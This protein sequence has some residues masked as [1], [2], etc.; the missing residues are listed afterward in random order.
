MKK[1][2]TA[3]FILFAA[4]SA[5][6]ESL[7]ITGTR[8][9]SEEHLIKTLNLNRYIHGHIDINQVNSL[10][11]DY[12]HREGYNLAVVYL[13]DDEKES[14]RLHVDEGRLGKIV[15]YNLSSLDTLRVKTVFRLKHRIFNIYEVR[16]NINTLAEKF[17]FYKISYKLVPSPDFDDSLFQLDRELELPVIGETRV[18]FLNRHGNRYDLEIYI[19]ERSPDDSPE[20]TRDPRLDFKLDISFSDGLIP[21]VVYY[22][23]DLFEDKDMLETGV[24]TGIFYGLDLDFESPPEFKFFKIQPIYT[25]AP[26][27]TEVFTPVLKGLF[28]QTAAARSD[29]GLNSYKYNQINMIA[30]PGFTFFDKL[31]FY[32]G[33]GFER[34]Q[35]FDS[36]ID[37]SSSYIADIEQ[38]TDYYRVFESR[39]RLEEIPI[40]LGNPYDK[41]IS[42]Y[43]S[44]YSSK[45]SFHKFIIEATWDF[46][47]ENKSIYSFSTAYRVNRGDIPFYHEHNV[48]NHSFR[49]LSEYYTNHAFSVGN[50]YRISVYREFISAGVFGD[51][52]IFEGSGYD[53]KG[54]NSGFAAGPTIRIVFL[55]QFEF[56][57]HAGRDLL[58]ADGSSGNLLSMSLSRKW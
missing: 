56:Y 36:K 19:E 2:I 17:E 3:A 52:T 25:F 34:V 58:V 33:A 5:S 45:L 22:R 32:A 50:E 30:A 7:R 27:L 54:T 20:K 41:N 40:R 55:D 37:H 46:L 38:R 44:N 51:F 35:F 49:G 47:F 10:I 14:T 13:I 53:V 18:P 24:S 26:V 43:Y 29:L 39:L 8:I 21:E 48:Q 4:A 9:Y 16:E 11:T 1:I 28:Y 42:L 57:C 31:R 12:Y 15:F 6:A 23:P